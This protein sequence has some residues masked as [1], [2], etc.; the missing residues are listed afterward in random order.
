M[1]SPQGALR[2][3]LRLPWNS[4]NGMLNMDDR[5]VPGKNTAPSIV[6]VFIEALSRLL[7]F[8]RRCC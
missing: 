4:K 5:K 2:E 1:G 7:A 6:V 8:A 3:D